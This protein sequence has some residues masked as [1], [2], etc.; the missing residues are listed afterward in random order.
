MN[1]IL[2]SLWTGSTMLIYI[3]CLRTTQSRRHTT[4]TTNKSLLTSLQQQFTHNKYTIITLLYKNFHCNQFSIY[5]FT[6][7]NLTRAMTRSTLNIVSSS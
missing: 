6:H 7:M 3:G 1:N 5:M 4:L 2:W